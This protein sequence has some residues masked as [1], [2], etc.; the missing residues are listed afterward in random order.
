MN[1]IFTNKL[2][3]MVARYENLH[4]IFDLNISFDI[5]TAVET[6][7]MKVFSIM[8]KTYWQEKP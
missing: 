8:D 5:N 7:E 3:K 2:I 6:L 4:D 1:I